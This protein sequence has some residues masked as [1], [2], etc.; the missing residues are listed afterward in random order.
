MAIPEEIYYNPPLLI[1]RVSYNLAHVLR[2]P[3]HPGPDIVE[4]VIY[5]TYVPSPYENGFDHFYALSWIYDRQLQQPVSYYRD[6]RVLYD[7]AR[8][9]L[10]TGY[11]P[12][13]ELSVEIRLT[14]NHSIDLP[15]PGFSA[16]VYPTYKDLPIKLYTRVLP[17]RHAEDLDDVWYEITVGEYT[18]AYLY[19]F[20]DVQKYLK[21]LLT[22]QTP[23][24]TDHC[25]IPR[26]MLPDP[27][28]LEFGEAYRA[29]YLPQDRPVDETR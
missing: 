22:D 14:P 18:A 29:H 4:G 12:A 20:E 17:H 11:F 9:A 6:H 23:F 21:A 25:P 15:Y 28:A 10:Q 2:D 26:S 27:D 3:P 1:K 13:D 5:D 24:P 7:A 16:F 19:Y 8:N